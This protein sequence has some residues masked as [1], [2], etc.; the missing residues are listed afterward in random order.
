MHPK[1]TNIDAYRDYSE[2]A[3]TRMAIQ[4][5][6]PILGICR[7]LQVI[8]VA[9]GGTMIQDIP[10]QVGGPLAHGESITREDWE[11]MPHSMQIAD[12]SLLARLLGTTSMPV[13]SLHHQALGTIGQ[14]IRAV[15]WSDDGV[16]EAVEG[17]GAH[18]LLA[19]QCHPEALYNQ[20]DT[21][22]QRMFGRFIDNAR[23][24]AQRRRSMVPN[25][26]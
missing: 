25:E 4:Q 12:D 8:N 10:D 9:L 13:N 3:L 23:H 18:F 24:F 11:H 16:I 21:R 6:L 19:V 17:T 5:Q 2:I 14:G 22:W 26:S 7:G 15:A 20:A 1:T